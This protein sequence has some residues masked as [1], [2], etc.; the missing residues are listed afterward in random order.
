MAPE[1]TPA[2]NLLPTSFIFVCVVRHSQVLYYTH[3]RILLL[4]SVSCHAYTF[5][6]IWLLLDCFLYRKWVSVICKAQ[7]QSKF[8]SI[9]SVPTS[10]MT[11]CVSLQADLYPYIQFLPQRWHNVSPYKDHSVN[12]MQE[13]K[14]WL[15]VLWE[16]ND[17]YIYTVRKNSV[18]MD[19]MG[20]A[21]YRNLG[22]WNVS[23]NLEAISKL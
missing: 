2:I 7:K 20:S 15:H 6:F 11:Q 5:N 18:I 14:C 10:D 12:A 4:I 9:H 16:M 8:I 17:T 13:K 3:V 19:V 23:K 21:I 1:F 22:L